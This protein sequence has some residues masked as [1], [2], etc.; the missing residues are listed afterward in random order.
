MRIEFND[1]MNILI[2]SNSHQKIIYKKCRRG[3]NACYDTTSFALK[4]VLKKYVVSLLLNILAESQI[5]IKSGSRS[6]QQC[7]FCARNKT[8]DTRQTFDIEIIFATCKSGFNPLGGQL[9]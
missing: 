5:C 6:L 7:F 9:L 3:I 8:R 4:E 2:V 1:S